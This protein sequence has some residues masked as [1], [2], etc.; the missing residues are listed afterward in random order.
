MVCA[1]G[2]GPP[3]ETPRRP[4]PARAGE[5][6]VREEYARSA[7][8]Y[9]RRWT[10]YLEVSLRASLEEIGTETGA[11]VLDVGCGTGA[12][13][14]R[15]RGRAPEAE[16][17]GVDLT[18][19]MLA[20]ARARLPSEVR[21]AVA[22]VHRLPFPDAR[23]DT[24]VSSSSLHHWSRPERAL[25]ELARVTRRGGRLVITDWTRDDLACRLYSRVLRLT[26]PSVR[27]PFRA[28]ELR[29]LLERVGFS[30]VT[31]RRYRVGVVWGMMT[32]Q[33]RKSAEA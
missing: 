6:A 26:H 23:F 29:R 5:R 32:L 12:L 27:R 1:S 14:E 11:R 8:E 19:E 20:V 17:W 33:G 22:D 9:D 28:A 7:R 4:A 24:V 3:E 2:I 18:P 16:L 25:R 31:S 21:L 30:R 15:L 13:L 10:R